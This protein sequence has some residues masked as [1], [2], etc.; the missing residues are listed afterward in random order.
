M[1]V[2]VTVQPVPR[3]YTDEEL[4]D[5]V[6]AVYCGAEIAS[7]PMAV[8]NQRGPTSVVSDFGNNAGLLVGP[9]IPDWSS[10]PPNTLSATVT[11][12]DIIVGD[13]SVDTIAAG[14]LQALR[15]LIGHC[16]RRGIELSSGT[17][18][19]TGAVTGVHDVRLSSKARVDYGSLGWFD[20]TF[21]PMQIRHAL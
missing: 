14:P 19:S 13:V 11:V 5:I 15:F 12:D 10:L 17:L 7:S 16:G 9:E 4:I 3:S 1:E 6:S 18:I 2:G 8:V 20:V 21:T